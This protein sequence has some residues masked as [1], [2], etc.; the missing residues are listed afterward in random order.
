MSLT[1]GLI[2]PPFAWIM[3]NRLETALEEQLHVV[4]HRMVVDL[5][6]GAKIPSRPASPRP[7]GLTLLP[8]RPKKVGNRRCKK[9]YWVYNQKSV[10]PSSGGLRVT[11]RFDIFTS[12]AQLRV[13]VTTADI[14]AYQPLLGSSTDL[15]STINSVGTP[16]P[17][18]ITTQAYIDRCSLHQGVYLGYRIQETVKLRPNLELLNRTH[19]KREG[20]RDEGLT[21][22]IQVLGVKNIIFVLI[23]KI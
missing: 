5:M 23:M 21:V 14:P 11:D 7:A 22:T 2:G 9:E 20:K 17:K 1:H 18:R 10:N 12:R 3:S 16:Q 15:Q 4:H 8:I 19:Q 6:L 13:E